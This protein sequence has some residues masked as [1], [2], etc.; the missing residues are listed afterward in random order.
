M[1]IA[2][3]SGDPTRND[4]IAVPLEDAAWRAVGLQQFEAA[5]SAD[6]SIYEQLIH[7]APAR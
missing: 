3:T 6:D 1:K 5:Y 2:D 4:Q 7:D